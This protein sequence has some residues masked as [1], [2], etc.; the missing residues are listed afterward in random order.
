MD[1]SL[2]QE[3]LKQ[4]IEIM[5]RYL[6]A[7]VEDR[8]LTEIEAESDHQRI[9][10]IESQLKPLISS[11]LYNEIDL[12]E[13]KT[14]ID[15]INK[16]N[17]L[18]GFKGIK[19]Q[20]FFNLIINSADNESECDQELKAAIAVPNNEEIASSRIKNF[21]SYVKRIGT[22]HVD[23]GGSKHSKPNLSSVPYFLSY[24]WQIQA[25][26]IW[27]V[28]YTN[29][30]NVM[31]DLNL[32]QPVGELSA[33]YIIYKHINEKLADIFTKESGKKFGFYDVEHVF[34]YKGGKPYEGN[35][36]INKEKADVIPTNFEVNKE[37]PEIDM[38]QILHLPESYVPPVVSILPEMARNSPDLR[39]AAKASGTSLERA[40]EKSINAAFTILGYETKLLGQGKGRVPDGLA[41]SV[42]DSY[43]ILWDAKIRGEAYSM[44][45]DDRAIKEYIVTQ[46]RELKRRRGLRNIYYFIISSC[47]TD[48]YDDSTR[49]LKMET[50]VNEVCLVEADA[51]VAMVDAKMRFPTE[52]SLGTDGLQRFFSSSGVLSAELIRGTLI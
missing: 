51:L 26:E 29:S 25:P 8:P 24:F 45:T 34:W 52:I 12:P 38:P 2:N 43:A 6:A 17:E 21:A 7:T 49:T 3:Q 28:Y 46:S 44:G 35:K 33:D 39:E 36:S 32:W 4:S 19:G 42:D 14:K 23:A 15:S 40:F 13:F 47:F 20:M 37:Q 30:V 16:R 27:P 9:L 48:D 18:W 11:Y 22:Q 5:R 50:D 1:I 41:L 31:N 10:L